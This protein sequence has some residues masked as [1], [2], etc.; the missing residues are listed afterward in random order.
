MGIAVLKQYILFAILM[1]LILATE[2]FSCNIGMYVIC[3]RGFFVHVIVHV[4]PSLCR[5]LVCAPGVW[6]SRTDH[7]N[8]WS[9]DIVVICA[10]VL[11]M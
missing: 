3:I 5:I 4:M 2:Q 10:L 11:M 7:N 1:S 9:P 6:C 8:I